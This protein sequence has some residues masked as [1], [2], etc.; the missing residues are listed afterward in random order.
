MV[1]S[2]RHWDTRYQR[3]V[4]AAPGERSASV[5][6]CPSV[7]SFV[8]PNVRTSDVRLTGRPV[9]PRVWST[10]GGPGGPGGPGHAPIGSCR[11]PI[12]RTY[13]H[14]CHI[15]RHRIILDG[16]GT[17]TVSIGIT[18]RVLYFCRIAAGGDA[19]DVPL[20]TRYLLGNLYWLGWKPPMAVKRGIV[21]YRRVPLIEGI[22]RR[23]EKTRVV[24][25]WRLITEKS[26]GIVGSFRAESSNSW[27]NDATIRCDGVPR[28]LVFLPI[29]TFFFGNLVSFVS[30]GI[31]D[32]ADIC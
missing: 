11:A 29:K 28:V 4:I 3:T 10:A 30:F 1:C 24:Y 12:F 5:G 14:A 6:R 7:R 8:R 27:M 2:P 15:V 21:E 9:A 20:F 16:M 32:L 26:F 31:R 23:R 19:V 13:G 18:R 17:G 25:R 22:Y